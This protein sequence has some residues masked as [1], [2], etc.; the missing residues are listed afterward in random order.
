LSR[1]AEGYHPCCGGWWW[2][3]FFE[4]SIVGYTDDMTIVIGAKF[5]N[6]NMCYSTAVMRENSSINPNTSIIPFTTRRDIRVLR[7]QTPIVT[8]T[9]MFMED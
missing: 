7:T 2:T 6:C 4:P 3:N 1:L 9:K 5:P 8:K